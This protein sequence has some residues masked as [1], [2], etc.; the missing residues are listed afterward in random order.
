MHTDS[1][2][3]RERD[4]AD[5]ALSLAWLLGPST[6]LLALDGGY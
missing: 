2:M 3:L 6:W 4:A 1:M 5:R